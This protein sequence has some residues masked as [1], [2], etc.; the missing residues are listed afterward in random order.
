VPDRSNVALAGA[1]LRLTVLHNT[2]SDR[3]RD[4]SKDSLYTTAA[5]VRSV[6]NSFLPCC[7]LGVRDSID[8][9]NVMESPLRMPLVEREWLPWPRRPVCGRRRE[10]RSRGKEK[11]GEGGRRRRRRRREKNRKDNMKENC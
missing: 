2:C 11:K 4:P 8:C 10:R 1:V 5:T 7:C 6:T 3:L 9:V